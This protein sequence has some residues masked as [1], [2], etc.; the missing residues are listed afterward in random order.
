VVV[1]LPRN[2]YF[3]GAIADARRIFEIIDVHAHN[4]HFRKEPSSVF[5]VDSTVVACAGVGNEAAHDRLCVC[6]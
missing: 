6:A 2:E 3:I 5:L 4:L 1:V